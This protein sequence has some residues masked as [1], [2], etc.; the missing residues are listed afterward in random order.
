MKG[1]LFAI[2]AIAIS[3]AASAGWMTAKANASPLPQPAAGFYQEHPWDEP[4]G[5]MREAQRSGFHEGVEAARHDF[6]D[7]RHK[8]ADDH[9]LYRHPPVE[10]ELRGDFREGYKRGYEAAMHHLREEQHDHDHDRY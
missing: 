1:K 4:P 5:E 7:R 9:E 6:Q 10:R 2:S 8:D 3:M